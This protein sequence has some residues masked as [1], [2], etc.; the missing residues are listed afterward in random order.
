VGQKNATNFRK[1]LSESEISDFRIISRNLINGSKKWFQSHNLEDSMV[2]SQEYRPTPQAAISHFG[3]TK[4]FFY[5]GRLNS[6][7]YIGLIKRALPDIKRIGGGKPFVFMQDN[8]PC[9][10]SAA[11]QAFLREKLPKFL[12]KSEWT[13]TPSR[14]F[15]RCLRSR[16]TRRHPRPWRRWRRPSW[17][18]GRKSLWAMSGNFWMHKFDATQAQSCARGFRRTYQVL[19]DSP[20]DALSINTALDMEEGFAM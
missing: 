12:P 15:G 10:S 2:S 13:W 5:E 6:A 8:T 17:S 9:H 3:K 18:R 14:I 1:Y 4:L 7:A 16:R 19:I 11:S 20:D